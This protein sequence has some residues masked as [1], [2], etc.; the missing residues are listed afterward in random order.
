MSTKSPV[1]KPKK[2]EKK[3]PPVAPTV[4]TKTAVAAS[5]P[6][7]PKPATSS[8]DQPPLLPPEEKTVS[9]RKKMLS[10]ILTD[11]D[12]Q[13]PKKDNQSDVAAKLKLL[14]KEGE[15]LGDNETDNSEDKISFKTDGVKKRAYRKGSGDSSPQT[16]KLKPD[17]EAQDIEKDRE[18]RTKSKDAEPS[19]DSKSDRKSE[20]KSRHSREDRLDLEADKVMTT[21]EA[22]LQEERDELIKKQE[23]QREK[24]RKEENERKIKRRQGVEERNKRRLEGDLKVRLFVV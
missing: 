4:V 7:R 19:K 14:A 12:E 2:K 9:V 1:V 8:E 24:S 13:V 17:K 6:P 18:S 20:E 15:K 16:K 11:T 21:H 3:A 23:R 5:V 10:K 22:K